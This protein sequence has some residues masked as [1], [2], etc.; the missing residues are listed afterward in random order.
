[1]STSA[2]KSAVVTKAMANA[3]LIRKLERSRQAS[4]HG[5][6]LHFVRY[7]WSVLE[8][9]QPLVEGRVLDVIAMHL[10]AV[11]RGEIRSLLINVPPAACSRCSLTSSGRCGLAPPPAWRPRFGRRC[12]RTLRHDSFRGSKRPAARPQMSLFLGPQVTPDRT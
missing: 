1:M 9:A 3:A 5:G 6:L 7:F 10:E 2:A 11:T 12:A 4:L 8:P